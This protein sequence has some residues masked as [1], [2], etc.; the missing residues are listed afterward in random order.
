MTNRKKL[1]PWEKEWAA[2]Q[3][4]E[5]NYLARQAEYKS[6][7]LNQMLE[8]KVPPNLQNTLNTAFVKAFALMFE[9]GSPLL[10]RTIPTSEISKQYQENQ[11]SADLRRDRR[12]LRSF[13]RRSGT[14]EAIHLTL[15]GV[16]GIVL[17]ALG[18]GIPDI[19]VFTGV[20]L[21]SLYEMA[22][23]FGFPYT[24]PQEQY[25]QL[26]LIQGAFSYGDDLLAC[27]R[28]LNRF[29]H[30][31][32]LPEGFDRSA[33]INKTARLLSQQLLYM[34]FLQGIPLVGVAGG[35]YDVVCLN[36]VQRFA[37]LK[38]QR[39]LLLKQKAR[40]AGQSRC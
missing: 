32:G 27:D 16:E 40:T 30:S 39:R 37:K 34:K 15:S 24:T 22:G 11:F 26:L 5:E 38:Y 2:L 31:P 25:F 10:E 12:S 4:R 36:R 6:P 19:P 13:S 18:V 9:K 14:A 29:I 28:E 3:K 1:S 21:R 33:Q 20:M 8:G 17:G 23:H 7:R 35:A